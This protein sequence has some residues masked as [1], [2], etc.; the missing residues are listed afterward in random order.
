MTHQGN[1]N[2]LT[3]IANDCAIR[4]DLVTFTFP[5]ICSAWQWILKRHCV[6][7]WTGFIW[8]RVCTKWHDSVHTVM[9]T[10]VPQKVGNILTSWATIGFWRTLLHGGGWNLANI[11]S[12]RRNNRKWY[13]RIYHSI[14]T[15]RVRKTMINLSLDSRSQDRDCNRGTKWEWLPAGQR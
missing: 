3:V 6:K 2:H 9:N 10:S 12:N 13:E 1:P 4:S 14:W 7:A 15:Y 11:A 8:L 5:K